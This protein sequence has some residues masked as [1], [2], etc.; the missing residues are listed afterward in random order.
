MGVPS[1]KNLLVANWPLR[2]D[3]GCLGDGLIW[4]D[5]VSSPESTRSSDSFSGLLLALPARHSAT[6]LCVLSATFIICP[7]S[8]TL[9]LKMSL[10][11]LNLFSSS[12]VGR[13]V[14]KGFVLRQLN[15][16]DFCPPVRFCVLF[17]PRAGYEVH[18][19]S[20][21]CHSLAL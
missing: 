14:T 4:K 7:G 13:M 5:F 15:S 1:I 19:K 3:G 8:L 9:C 11:V 12:F 6:L 21:W 17:L 20:D 18:D 10:Q 2:V 16:V